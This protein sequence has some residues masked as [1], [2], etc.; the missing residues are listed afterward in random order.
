MVQYER[1]K[2]HRLQMCAADSSSRACKMPLYISTH[3]TP[4]RIPERTLTAC[5]AAA[6]CKPHPLS[7]QLHSHKLPQ[8]CHHPQGKSPPQLPHH[9]S[10]FNPECN[11]RTRD[12]MRWQGSQ[13]RLPLPERKA[14]TV[15]CVPNGSRCA[16][17]LLSCFIRPCRI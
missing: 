16:L 14:A 1:V 12:V 15:S 5:P 10:R 8:C 11:A 7:P 6:T 3:A 13:Q 4:C 17:L 9:R 2:V